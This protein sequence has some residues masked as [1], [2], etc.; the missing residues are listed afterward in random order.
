M[1]KNN[2]WRLPLYSVQPWHILISLKPWPSRLASRHKAESLAFLANSFGQALRPFALLA[3]TCTHF[4]RDQICTQ[5]IKSATQAKSTQVERR[6]FVVITTCQP[7]KYR[8]CIL[9][10]A[11]PL[12]QGLTE[13]LI[14]FLVKL[15]GS[16]WWTWIERKRWD[17]RSHGDDIYFS[18]LNSS[19]FGLSQGF[20]HYFT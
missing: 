2:R 3:M 8:T 11:N 7:I 20:V 6:P 14:G 18:L 19:F 12:S 13:I 1:S 9:E 4:G 17:H 16:A 5:V 15:I 10:M